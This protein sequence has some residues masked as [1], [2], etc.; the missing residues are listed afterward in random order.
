MQNV[1]FRLHR[2]AM[3]PRQ[4]L[5][6][7]A[8]R[9]YR[10]I[11]ID[12]VDTRP[13]RCPQQRAGG[14]RLCLGRHRRHQNAIGLAT[15]ARGDPQAVPQRDDI[16]SGPVSLDH[17]VAVDDD[18]RAGPGMHDSHAIGRRWAGSA[19][20]GGTNPARMTG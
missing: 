10:R 11:R 6:G 4:Q 19:C 12:N 1:V 18:L 5:T 15:R 3:Q 8:P 7:F 9:H 16:G 14:G 20:H 17:D 2:N 13:A